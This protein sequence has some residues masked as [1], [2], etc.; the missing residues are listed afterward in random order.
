M[1]RRFRGEQFWYRHDAIR[2]LL[3]EV[4]DKVNSILEDNTKKDDFI[5][6]ECHEFPHSN[7]HENEKFSFDYSKCHYV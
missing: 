4:N 1:S 3:K 2:D 5:E 7:G 6:V